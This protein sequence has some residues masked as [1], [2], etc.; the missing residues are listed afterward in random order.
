MIADGVPA[1]VDVPLNAGDA[2]TAF[3]GGKYRPELLSAIRR[4]STKAAVC[5]RGEPSAPSSNGQVSSK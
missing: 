4:S 5:G 1:D 2:G 3:S